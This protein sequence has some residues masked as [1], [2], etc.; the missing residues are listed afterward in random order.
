MKKIGLL[1]VL[2]FILTSISMAVQVTF[3]TVPPQSLIYVNG[4]L[5]GQTNMNGTLT[6]NINSTSNISV[7]DIGYMPSNFIYDPSS[8]STMLTVNLKPTSYLYVTTSP[9]EA[10]VF[11]DGEQ[12]IAPATIT[13]YPGNHTLLVEKKG[14][15]SKKLSISTSPF[16][17]TSQKVSLQPAGLVY[18]TSA[19]SY[20]PILM[21]GQYVGKTPFSTVLSAGVHFIT[22][23]ATNFSESSTYLSISA[24]ATPQYLFFKL[25]KILSV[26][27]SASPFN[28]EINMNGKTFVTPQ[29]LELP[30][31]TYIYSASAEYYQTKVGTLSI[32]KSGNY[33]IFLKPM[34]ALV[35]FSSN[36]PGAAVK[37]N[38]NLVGQTTLSKQ[39]PYGIYNVKMI[40]VG[41]KIWFGNVKVDQQVA[42][43]YGD[44]INAGMVLISATPSHDT[45][46]HI[47]QIWSTLPA[48]LTASV[49]IYPVEF[50]NPN[51]P[52]KT[53]YLKINGGSVTNLYEYLQPM[54]DLFIG[55]TPQGA[56]VTLNGNLIGKTP[57]FDA[58][59]LPGNYEM[60]MSWPD[61]TIKRSLD[62]QGD[63]V[64]TV[65]LTDPAFVDIKFISF[66]DPV[67]VVIDGHDEGYTPFIVKLIRG[68]HAYQVYDLLGKQIQ[69]GIIDTNSM[70]S[71][72]YFFIGG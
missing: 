52:V 38:G 32:T 62:I 56:T 25:K 18:F 49:G 59:L 45:I 23:K 19:P 69:S 15:I 14:Y 50:Y 37:I 58:K 35:V 40:G 48:T 21:D 70:A 6:V 53:F 46:V 64:Y 41:G 4:T 16:Q 67:K 39:M 55:S 12:F 34:T 42:N 68:V 65:Y 8:E 5:V 44:M 66:P 33:E 47:G 71:K 24:N 9:T 22:L 36:P 27:I 63:Q 28:A 61:T 43:I 54:G 29:T 26:T 72:S 17:I 7:Q 1:M 31:G 30:V 51:F 10:T 3:V 57:I 60:S 20:I 11:L 2:I 13:T